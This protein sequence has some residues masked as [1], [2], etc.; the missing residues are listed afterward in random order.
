LRAQAVAPV[1]FRRKQRDM[2]VDAATPTNLYQRLIKPDI[3]I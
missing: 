1:S 2:S 3:G